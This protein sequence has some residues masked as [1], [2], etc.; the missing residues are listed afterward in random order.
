ML[1]V[2]MAFIIFSCS[3]DNGMKLEQGTPAYTLAE[4]L[5][6]VVPDFDPKVN[7]VIVKANSFKITAGD[8]VDR[9]RSN[10]GKQADILPSQ[11]EAN[12]KQMLKEFGERLAIDKII[13]TEAANKGI[14]VTEAELDS[15]VKVQFE[16]N[17][18]EE[19]FLGLL[20]ENGVTLETVKRDIKTAEIANRYVEKLR[21]ELV[22]VTEAQI[23]SQYIEDKTA[24]VRH[25]LL[26]TQGKPEKE[27]EAQLKKIKNLLKRAKNG[28]SFEAL[29]KRYSED[30]GSKDKGGLY[31]DFPKGQMVPSFE[32]AAFTVPVGE[33]SDV[34]ET[35]YG[36][37][38]LQIVDRKKEQRS[39][40]EVKNE[41]VMLQSRDMLQNKIEELKTEHGYTLV[42]AQ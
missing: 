36:Y 33:L 23:D 32:N 1:A 27:K 35:T 7:K 15:V 11:P 9:M 10:F 25:I 40:D 41:L 14:V 6:V 19:K 17:G 24:S 21:E 39:R 31:S 4:S 22:N 38:I 42:E 16:A 5:A 13:L 30:P 29:A 12:L 8:V 28:E 34:V 26:M 37:H 2:L 18:G 3:T 20:K